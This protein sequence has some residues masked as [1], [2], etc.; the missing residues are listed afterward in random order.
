MNSDIL[1]FLEAMGYASRSYYCRYDGNTS[2]ADSLLGIKYVLTRN[3]DSSTILNKTYTPVFTYDYTYES[4][5][6]QTITA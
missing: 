6:P 2:L 4:D 5:T 1:S 3:S